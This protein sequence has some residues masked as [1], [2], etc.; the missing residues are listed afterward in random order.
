MEILKLRRLCWSVG[1]LIVVVMLHWIPAEAQSVPAVTLKAAFVYNFVKFTEWPVN[2]LGRGDR[3]SLCVVGDS[4]VADALQKTIE[5]GGVDGHPL[6]VEMIAPDGPLRTCHL[7]YTSGLDGKRTGQLLSVVKNTSVFT[8]SDV[9]HFAE[10][11]GVAQL[12]QE[13]NRLRFAV[14]TDAAQRARLKISSRLLTLAE[15]VKDR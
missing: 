10:M 7:L 8:V 9:E 5:V 15:I 1:L 13:N 2:S 3:L 14:N 6:S 4:G 11:G 12:I